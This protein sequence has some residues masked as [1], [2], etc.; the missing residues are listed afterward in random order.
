[1]NEEIVVHMIFGSHLYGTN[2]PDSDT[3]YKGIFL[4]SREQ[5]FLGKIPKSYSTS[6][7]KTEEGQ[8]IR[9]VI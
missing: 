4:P 9:L 1:M 8:R 6:P 7:K 5:V 2:T 3:D